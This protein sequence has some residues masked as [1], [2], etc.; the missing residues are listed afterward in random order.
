M[1]LLA[2]CARK[3]APPPPPPSPQEVT[4]T[5]TNFAFTGPDSIGPGVTSIRLVNNGTQ[6]HHM[7]LGRLAEG[8]TMQDLVTFTQANP[9][10]APDFVTW[11]G[12]A[13]GIAPQA[14]NTVIAD[15]APGRDVAFC[16][17]PDP[18]D[19]QMHATKGMVQELTVP[20]S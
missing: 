17:L 13:G 20:A 1:L 14:T 10:K 3:D 4:F 15:L 2:A 12:A 6:N 7:I 18:A 5:A 19:G 11:H 9:A 16:Y 8:K